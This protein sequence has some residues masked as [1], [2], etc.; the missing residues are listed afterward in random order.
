MIF[1]VT[2]FWIEAF[3]IVWA[4][5][6]Y[7]LSLKLLKRCVKGRGLEKDYEAK[8]TVTVM[9]VAHNEEKVIA[10]KLENVIANDYPPEKIEYLVTS[11]YSTDRTNEIVEDFI[12]SHPEL[13][14]RLHKAV[15]HKGKTNAQNEAQKLV[16]SEILVMTDANAMFQR[17]AVTELTA[18][19]A[20]EDVAY[21]TG[22]LV[23]QNTD[24][25]TAAAESS[26]WEGD[27]A[28]RKT[29]S[30]IYTITAGNGAI[31][32]CRN[33]LY[34]DLSPMKSHDAHMP[35]HYGMQGLRAVY[36]P[37]AIA[38]EKAGEVIEDEFKRKVR[39][40]R[41][42][43][44]DLGEAF[45]AINIFRHGWFSYFYFGHRFCRRF[46]WLAHLLVWVLSG[47]LALW[48]GAAAGYMAGFF[49]VGAWFWLVTF[50]GQTLFYLL[51]AIALVSRSKNRILKMMG[52]YTMTIAAQWAGVYNCL[53]G[54]SKPTWDK[55][56]STR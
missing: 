54:R 31:Y 52:Y 26:Y 2:L 12:G 40:N 33:E 41:N 13:R 45:A 6:G 48:T 30:D 3:L 39:M 23:Y 44:H 1:L 18:C 19:F 29:E 21:V 53:T 14:I 5:G 17:N 7:K 37:D 49:S 55:A 11:D 9:I 4:M 28:Q 36:N 25:A 38:A 10:N 50:G 24:N 32:A 47:I 15:E 16:D 35:R 51:S 46:L 56:E 20:S 8:P 22:R 34:F 43:L 42:I 27:L